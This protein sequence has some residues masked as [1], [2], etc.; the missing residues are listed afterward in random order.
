LTTALI[1]LRSLATRLTVRKTNPA[2]IDV[3]RN[4]RPVYASLGPQGCSLTGAKGP[5]RGYPTWNMDGEDFYTVQEAARILRTT[6]RTVRRRLERRD[7]EGT[8]DPTTGRWKVA[9]RSVTAALSDRPP[10]ESQE[11]LE[12][13]QEAAGLREKVESLQRELG[14]LEGRLELTEMAESTLREQLERERERAD[15]A[16][17]ELRD[18]RRSWWSRIFGQ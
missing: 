12:S 6:E 10:K 16:E 7:L 11:A 8:R 15:R 5:L 2:A 1:F 4:T 18:A 17:E 13:S 9:A 14:R 3:R